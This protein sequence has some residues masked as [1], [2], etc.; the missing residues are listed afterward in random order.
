MTF[1]VCIHDTLFASYPLLIPCFGFYLIAL[2]KWPL[3]T[4]FPLICLYCTILYS[5]DPP[6]GETRGL[7][8]ISSMQKMETPF[9]T[10]YSYKGTL[11]LPSGKI[12]CSIATQD[13]QPATTHFFVTGVLEKRA[14][15]DFAFKAKEWEKVPDSV[16]FAASRYKMKERFFSFLQSS[17]PFDPHIADFFFALTTGELQNRLLRFHFQRLGLEHILGVSGFHFAMLAA[18]FSFGFISFLP[19]SWRVFLLLLGLTAYYFFVGQTPAVERCW[20]MA[21]G[22][23]IGK[24][25]NREANGLNLLGVAML[26]ELIA[27]P[28]ALANIGFQLSFTSCIGISLFYSLFEKKLRTLW[29]KRT[30]KELSGISPGA[31]HLLFLISWIRRALSLTLSVNLAIFPLLLLHSH[32]FPPLSLLYNLFY[33]FCADAA[34]ALF[35]IS[36][37]LHFLFPLFATPFFFLT[38]HFAAL[39][40]KL[41]SSPPLFLDRPLLV[42]KFPSELLPI[43]FFFLFSWFTTHYYSKAKKEEFPF[44]G[45]TRYNDRLFWRS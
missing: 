15:Y 17:F 11:Y 28:L 22:Y 33:P 19:S 14:P 3:L 37:L 32:S 29:P 7:F 35:A 42:P 6:V 24:W 16:T 45:A 8:S 21:S 38:Q 9:H 44:S 5:F 20:L 34:L 36:T 25:L 2:R 13:L 12:P 43:Y 31:K 41:A 39:L 26:I 23:L 27:N 18:L 40:L 10:S 30:S 1:I 4:L